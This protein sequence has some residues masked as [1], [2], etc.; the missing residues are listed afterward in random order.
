MPGKLIGVYE[1]TAAASAS[2]S[3]LHAAQQQQFL[4]GPETSGTK[5]LAR[6]HEARAPTHTTKRDPCSSSINPLRH[7]APG[8]ALTAE[9]PAWR[10]SSLSQPSLDAGRQP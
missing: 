1:D 10:Q 5:A 3:A 2:S 4:G 6:A 8:S 7:A 9:R